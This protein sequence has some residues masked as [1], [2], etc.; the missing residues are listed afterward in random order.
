MRSEER[1][2]ER[3]VPSI[4]GGTTVEDYRVFY[5]VVGMH[6]Q[7][8]AA[9]EVMMKVQCLIQSKGVCL[10]QQRTRMLVSIWCCDLGSHS[11]G[12][13]TITY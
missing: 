1:M 3:G 10:G 6:F 8:A 11:L 7:F 13:S 2:K 9:T 5:L 12:E 4:F